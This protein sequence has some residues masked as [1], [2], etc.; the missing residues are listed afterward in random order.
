[1]CNRTYFCIDGS[2]FYMENHNHYTRFGLKNFTL[3]NKRVNLFYNLTDLYLYPYGETRTNWTKQDLSNQRVRSVSVHF[4]KKS[5]CTKQTSKTNTLANEKKKRDPS[6]VKGWN[7]H[8]S[9]TSKQPNAG[10]NQTK[11]MTIFLIFISLRICRMRE[12]RWQTFTGKRNCLCL[13]AAAE[14]HT[15]TCTILWIFS[16]FRHTQSDN[17]L[18]NKTNCK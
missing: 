11:S 13:A 15:H 4:V 18:L 16:L 3:Y 6:K 1:M 17:K 12:E 7:K 9:V 5:S 14:T 10:S 2:S 8:L